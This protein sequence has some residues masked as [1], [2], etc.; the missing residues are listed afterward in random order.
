M[1][2]TAQTT[3]DSEIGPELWGI[4]PGSIRRPLPVGFDDAEL[5]LCHEHARDVVRDI[6]VGGE[7]V[8]GKNP[9][10]LLLWGPTGTGKS[11]VAALMHAHY[12]GVSCFVRANRFVQDIVTCRSSR[13]KV[14]SQRYQGGDPQYRGTSY[15]RTEKQ[16]WNM[17][18]RQDSL[19]VIDEL[20]LDN[21][22][23]TGKEVIY[24]LLDLRQ[25]KPTIITCNRD[26]A[27]IAKQFDDR[28][29][30]RISCGTQIKVD[31]DDRRK[32]NGESR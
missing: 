28:V 24:T 23:A 11:Y 13:G 2:T 25:K 26:L 8:N 9:Y 4:G 1:G 7:R 20:M 27:G 30:T 5:E 17:V 3:S 22:T 15:E 19:W 18:C 29:A 10:P 6:V 21:Q 31:G 32:L 12:E 14:A 16:I